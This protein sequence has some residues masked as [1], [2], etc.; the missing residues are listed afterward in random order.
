[1]IEIIGDR[2]RKESLLYSI[3][4]RSALVSVLSKE[5]SEQFQNLVDST[6]IDNAVPIEKEDLSQFGIGEGK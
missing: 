4:I 2:K 3:S 6:F 1:M 5:G